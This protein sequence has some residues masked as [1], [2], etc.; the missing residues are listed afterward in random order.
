MT[1]EDKLAGANY[2]LLFMQ[3]L[4]TLLDYAASYINFLSQ[5]KKKYS[6]LEEQE[7]EDADRQTLLNNVAAIK[8]IIFK[9]YV[10]YSVLKDY[11]GI[12]DD[13]KDK[14]IKDIWENIKGEAIPKAE[15]VEEF[16]ISVHNVFANK[17]MQELVTTAREVTRGLVE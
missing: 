16:V 6:N 1:E 14:K 17:M 5:L 7:L 4:E 13:K 9:V 2:V 15:R 3:D 12:K 11:L 8:N 10:R